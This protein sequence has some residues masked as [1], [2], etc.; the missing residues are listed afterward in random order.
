MTQQTIEIN[1]PSRLASVSEVAQQTATLLAQTQLGDDVAFG[2]DMAVREAVA[3]AIL[4]GNKQDAAKQ[5]EVEIG[6][7]HV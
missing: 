5:V 7:A 2:I 3:N 1:L 4:H 6:R